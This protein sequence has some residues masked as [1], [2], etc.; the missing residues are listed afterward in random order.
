MTTPGGPLDKYKTIKNRLL[1]NNDYGPITK[2]RN[3][4]SN[5]AL[6]IRSSENI[7]SSDSIGNVV[8]SKRDYA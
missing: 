3:Q 7:A 2:N 4:D 5:P 1:N 8:D 6:H